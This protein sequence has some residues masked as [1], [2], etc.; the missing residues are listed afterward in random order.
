M[1]SV[2]QSISQTLHSTSA[3]LVSPV[4]DVYL[5]SDNPDALYTLLRRTLTSLTHH[6]KDAEAFSSVTEPIIAQFCCTVS[7]T[8]RDEVGVERVRRM[9]HLASVLCGARQGS[10]LTGTSMLFLSSHLSSLVRVPTVSVSFYI[11]IGHSHVP[12]I[13]GIRAINIRRL[14]PYGRR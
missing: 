10:R 7:E 14:C 12:S 8:P 3:S 9:L 13:N 6:C 2:L 5:S 1:E 11:G 4:V